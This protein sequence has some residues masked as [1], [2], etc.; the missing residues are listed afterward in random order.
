MVHLTLQESREENQELK[1]ELDIIKL[2]ANNIK[3]KGNSLFGE[4]SYECHL[5]NTSLEIVNG[6]LH[7]S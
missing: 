6:W 2:E 3:K 7:E 1:V 5:K 4:V